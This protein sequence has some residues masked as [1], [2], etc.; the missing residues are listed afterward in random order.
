MKKRPSRADET[1]KKLLHKF[2]AHDYNYQFYARTL[3]RQEN[4]K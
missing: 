3:Q 4:R 2:D 1:I